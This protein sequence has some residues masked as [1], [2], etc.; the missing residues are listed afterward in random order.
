MPLARPE[1]PLEEGLAALV[2]E[3]VDGAHGR[4]HRARARRH[5]APRGF[6]GGAPIGDALRR[7]AQIRGH[8][9]VQLGDAGRQAEGPGLV[10]GLHQEVVLPRGQR[11]AHDHVVELLVV[12]LVVRSD[13]LAV[14]PDAH[15]VGGGEAE[16][17]LPAARRLDPG[18]RVGHHG[19]GRPDHVAE[20]EGAVERAR[21]QR[22]EADGQARARV[23]ARRIRAL[24]RRIRGLEALA[25]LVVEGAEHLPRVDEAEPVDELG[26]VLVLALEAQLAR[27]IEGGELAHR[28]PRVALG[29]VA[30][31]RLGLEVL[32][33]GAR[34]PAHLV[35]VE[36]G[37]DR[38]LVG[39]RGEEVRERRVRVGAD[40]GVVA[41]DLVQPGVSGRAQEGGGDGLLVGAFGAV[42]AR[43]QR[44]GLPR[45]GRRG[46]RRRRLRHEIAVA[47]LDGGAAERRGGEEE[48]RQ[49]GSSHGRRHGSGAA[50][51][52][53]P[54]KRGE[55][56]PDEV[57]PSV[58]G[59]ARGSPARPP[60]RA[61]RPA[62]RRRPP[63]RPPS[64]TSSSPCWTRCPSRRPRRRRPRW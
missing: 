52:G 16:V 3:L 60:A 61:T 58:T 7:P 62:R 30:Q 27:E 21:G 56:C 8:R 19:V 13:Q 59:D 26:G 38:A 64:G 48:R 35:E 15:G 50:G 28:E 1:P 6:G 44:V 9:A 43:D 54:R 18:L 10:R 17:D 22:A 33:G 51:S 4:H 2:R 41:G 20:R 37:R 34:V 47:L 32:A 42:E 53:P 12:D 36:L 57:T 46:Q 11:H 55:I 24:L 63:R 14:E 25:L 23:R 5:W 31:E 39:R 49:I 29:E 45:G 40:N